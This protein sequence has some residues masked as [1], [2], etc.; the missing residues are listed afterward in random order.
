MLASK[1]H[2]YYSVVHNSICAVT[3]I[4][5]EGNQRI[6]MQMWYRLQKVTQRYVNKQVLA[7]KHTYLNLRK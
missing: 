4:I 6:T 1:F 3:N 5:K 2:E 7:L